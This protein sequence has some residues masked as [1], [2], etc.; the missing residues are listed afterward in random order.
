MEA[1]RL[2]GRLLMTLLSS[3]FDFVLD[4]FPF[5]VTVFNRSSVEAMNIVV[6]SHSSIYLLIK[7]CT[8]DI[9]IPFKWIKINCY[10]T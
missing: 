3:T 4:S 2:L 10:V 7:S 5:F 8:R 6:A 9:L 1:L